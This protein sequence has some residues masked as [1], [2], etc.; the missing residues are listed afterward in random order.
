M[1]TGNLIWFSELLFLDSNAN[2]TQTILRQ[3][4]SILTNV[5]LSHLHVTG[6]LSIGIV[7][8]PLEEQL[9]N[10]LPLWWPNDPILIVFQFLGTYFNCIMFMVASSVVTTIMILNYH[11]RQADTHEM[12]S[13]VRIFH[14]ILETGFLLSIRVSISI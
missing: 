13:W 10:K 7:S 6:L 14:L 4:F 9:L 2:S 3:N 12:P 8:D 5:S 1:E 11:H